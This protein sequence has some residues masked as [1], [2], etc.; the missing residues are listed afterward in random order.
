MGHRDDVLLRQAERVRDAAVFVRAELVKVVADDGE[1][2][3]I[4][5]ALA[6]QILELDQQALLQGARADA[7]G[8]ERLQPRQH[9]LDLVG[10][11][12][13][14]RGDLVHRAAQE[15][16]V[17]EVADQVLGYAFL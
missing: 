4:A 3:R 11:D 17:V 10:S 16:V 14:D 15:A 2:R 8:F 6:L 9:L 1:G 7:D 12:I 5:I 13:Q